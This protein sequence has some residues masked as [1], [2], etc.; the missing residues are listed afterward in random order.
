M[1]LVHDDSVDMLWKKLQLLRCTTKRA[2][3][4]LKSLQDE[5]RMLNTQSGIY[6]TLS[7]FS[8]L[9]ACLDNLICKSNL[10]RKSLA[11]SSSGAVGWLSGSWGLGEEL[12]PSWA[13][14]SPSSQ[15]GELSTVSFSGDSSELSP[16]NS[17]GF[18]DITGIFRVFLRNIQSLVNSLFALFICS[19]WKR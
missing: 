11:D 6:L 17:N 1:C 19:I 13:V 5:M 14:T 12:L 2:Q 7:S 3:F 8:F 9:A 10:W 15:E 16:L 18:S 4:R